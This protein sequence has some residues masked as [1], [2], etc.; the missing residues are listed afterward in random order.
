MLDVPPL[1]ALPPRD[2]H[3]HKGTFGT[4]VVL[5]GCARHRALD[6]A[7]VNPGTLHM[8]G[9]AC[10]SAVAALRTGCGLA[11]LLLPEP[12]VDHAFA[13]APSATAIGL[14]VE[15]DGDI[16]PHEAAAVIDSILDETQCLA[17]G[18]GM[19]VSP[20]ASAAVMRAVT[21]DTVPLVL[22][23][24]ALNNLADVRELNAD[25]RAPCVLTPHPGEFKRLAGSLGITA[26]PLDASARA[27]A[28]EQLAQKLGAVVVLKSAA[29]VV[30][31]GQRTWVHDKPNPALATAGTGDVL[32][33]VIAG[34]IAQH[35][36]IDAFP[37]IGAARATAGAGAAA[38]ATTPP[39]SLSL[40]DA[41]RLGVAIHAQAARD[42]TERHHTGSGLI[43]PELLEL[44]PTAAQAF[45]GEK[46]G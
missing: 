41:A 4:V 20:G 16:T 38:G 37:A 27:G 15:H 22:D 13:I 28:A 7:D 29:T 45:R 30:S 44:I 43:V 18:P 39:T 40:F 32:T 6:P 36:R 42:W 8:L 12:L 11:K 35:V 23:A 25:F 21:Q 34:L 2:P 17:V 24:D 33:G 46:T 5:G 19:G 14:P 1:P 3:G 26:D 31:D 10:F 9:G